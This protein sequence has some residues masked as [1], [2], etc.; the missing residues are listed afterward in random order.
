MISLLSGF[1]N[2]LCRRNL[3]FVTFH[4]ALAPGETVH[5]NQAL[6]RTEQQRLIRLMSRSVRLLYPNSSLTLLTDARTANSGLSL[7]GRQVINEVKP[8]N[9]M[10]ERA[11]AQH[12]YVLASDMSAPIVLLDSDILL[13]GSLENVFQ[14]TFDVALTWRPHDEMPINGGFL[15]LN[16]V[17]PEASKEFFSRFLSIYRKKYAAQAGWF[18]D[19]L[20]L[21]DCVGLRADNMSEREI[22]E[23]DGCRVLLLPCST[24][25]FAPVNRYRS[26]CSR[27]PEKVVLHFKGQRKRLMAAFWRAWLYPS[28]SRLPWAQFSGWRE[29]RWIARLAEV[30]RAG[31]SAT[32][33]EQVRTSI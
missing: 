24:Y 20:A 9:L 30:E 5:P 27:L 4:V 32:M 18:G 10:L 11:V 8:E 6:E 25:N 33:V 2:E 7:P 19:Q 16:N 3:E 1:N 28:Y 22:I 15:I 29:R 14:Q 26:I 13:N 31:S 17:R 21:R 23:R 12:R